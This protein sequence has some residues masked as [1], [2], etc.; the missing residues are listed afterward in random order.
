MTTTEPAATPAAQ[1][2]AGPSRARIITARVLVVLGV[3][4]VDRQPA[5]ELRPA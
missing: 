4:L 3:V 1:A 5:R 2:P